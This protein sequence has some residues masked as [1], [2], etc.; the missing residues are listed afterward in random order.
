MI[1]GFIIIV[2]VLLSLTGLSAAVENACVGCHASVGA[3][4][5]IV[6]DWKESKHALKNVTC[7]KC[8]EAADK[9]IKTR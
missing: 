5:G 9:V 4:K 3:T 1:K 2:M 6:N 8:H 7:D